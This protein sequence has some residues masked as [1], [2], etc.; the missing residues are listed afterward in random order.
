MKYLTDKPHPCICWKS[1]SDGLFHCP[2]F[3]PSGPAGSHHFRACAVIA[4]FSC[5]CHVLSLVPSLCTGTALILWNRPS[6]VCTR[7]GT[8]MVPLAKRSPLFAHFCNAHGRS[9]RRSIS[10]VRWRRCNQFLRRMATLDRLSAAFYSR[11]WKASR[12]ALVNKEKCTRC[13]HTSSLA[14]PQVSCF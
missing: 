4:L 10:M 2:I 3:Q 14:W 6:P 1:S 5:Q 12:C 13:V 9:A 8:V 7:G 11:P